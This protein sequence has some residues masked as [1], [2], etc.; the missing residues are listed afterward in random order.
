MDVTL[1]PETQRLLEDQMKRR[2]GASADEV[3]HAALQA[4]HDVEEE[5]LESLDPETLAAIDE[6]EAQS[7]RG[8]WR[9]WAEVREELRARFINK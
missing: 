2:V 8:E 3:V 5:P 9:D 4:L 1:S 7:A 6:A